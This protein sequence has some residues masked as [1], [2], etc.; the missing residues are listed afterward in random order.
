VTVVVGEG[1]KPSRVVIFMIMKR[2]TRRTATARERKGTKGKKRGNSRELP[3]PRPTARE[4]KG[5]K[6][7]KRERKGEQ[8]GTATTTTTTKTTAVDKG[9][10]A[11]WKPALPVTTKANKPPPPAAAPPLKR[12]L[13]SRW[14][15]PAEQY[16]GQAAKTAVISG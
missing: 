3:Q 6:G 16:G 2:R 15:Q 14:R 4:R 5:T 10:D 8:Q 13:C 9:I 11:G 12:G 7:K 1:F